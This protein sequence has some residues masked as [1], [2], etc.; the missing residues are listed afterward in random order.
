MTIKIVTILPS[1]KDG[2]TFT[3]DNS[4]DANKERDLQDANGFD[5]RVEWVC[6]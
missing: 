3:F 6:K 1:G 4:I 5:Y 2:H